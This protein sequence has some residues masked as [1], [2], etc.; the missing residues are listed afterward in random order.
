MKV[1]KLPNDQAYQHWTA[2]LVEHT[3]DFS[4]RRL[5]TRD[6]FHILSGVLETVHLE[7]FRR[8]L[9]CIHP[10]DEIIV[11][12]SFDVSIPTKRPVGSL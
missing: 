2:G 8:F 1:A 10:H 5:P 9:H 6:V 12:Q 7:V 4:S 11:P 3:G